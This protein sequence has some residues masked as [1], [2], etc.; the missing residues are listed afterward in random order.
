MNDEDHSNGGTPYQG[1]PNNAQFAGCILAA[2]ETL[3]TRRWNGSGGKGRRFGRKGRELDMMDRACH[4][5]EAAS[6]RLE[7]GDFTT[8]DEL[9]G[10]QA[11]I[12]DEVFNQFA[13][14]AVY[15]PPLLHF[16]MKMA[17]KAQSQC[18]STVKS[19]TSLK[20][21]QARTGGEKKSRNSCE[22]TIEDAKMPA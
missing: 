12:L 18:R 9:L 8:F 11:I 20:N 5:V 1:N 6:A 21:A 17:L 22:Q 10:N 3:T 2:L 15:N 19:M 7:A 4:I 14:L 13:R 16:S